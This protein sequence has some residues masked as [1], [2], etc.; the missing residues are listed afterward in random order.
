MQEQ[1]FVVVRRGDVGA[2]LR[3][4]A[5]CSHEPAPPF[6]EADIAARY[7]GFDGPMFPRP[8]DVPFEGR[9]AASDAL[10]QLQEFC[11]SLGPEVS[12]DIIYLDTSATGGGERNACLSDLTFLGYD[13]GFYQWQ[14]NKWSVIVCE[15][16][17]HTYPE[18]EA[19]ATRLNSHLLLPDVEAAY[20]V[21]ETRAHLVERGGE[22]EGR[23]ETT[24]PGEEFR[25]VGIY[26]L[27]R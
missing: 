20:R 7:R 25:P 27:H 21:Q 23:L 9:P 13:F 1:G 16:L 19:F 22:R 10:S 24:I 18:L 4:P 14:Y 3:E 12:C 17:Q 15:I 8:D 6:S 5:A 2:W 26:A 11:G